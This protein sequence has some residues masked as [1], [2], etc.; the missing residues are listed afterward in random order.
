MITQLP[1][2]LLDL[3][4]DRME[5]LL[6]AM[7]LEIKA[8][9]TAAEAA[10]AAAEADMKAVAAEAKEVEAVMKEAEAEVLM[11]EAEA[12]DFLLAVVVVEVLRV[13]VLA[14]APVVEDSL[15]RLR[16]VVAAAVEAVEPVEPQVEDQRLSLIDVYKMVALLVEVV[17][18][19]PPLAAPEPPIV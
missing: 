18:K 9:A 6:D 15:L 5:S 7:V 4:E 16:M 1:T 12:V 11:K 10:A 19:M 14:V 17:Q 8:K 2:V 13:L 3:F